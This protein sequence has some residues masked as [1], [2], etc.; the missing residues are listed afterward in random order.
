MNKKSKKENR[1]EEERIT[2][3]G[4]GAKGAKTMGE[5]LKV[6]TTLMNICL[7]SE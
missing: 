1:E 4:I 3:N 6:N 5:M 7:N 2:G